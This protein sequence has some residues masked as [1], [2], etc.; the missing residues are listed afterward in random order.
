MNRITAGNI[1]LGAL[2]ALLLLL[3]VRSRSEGFMTPTAAKAIFI[4]SYSRYESENSR[5]NKIVRP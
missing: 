4:N 5:G 1:L 3:F 2:A